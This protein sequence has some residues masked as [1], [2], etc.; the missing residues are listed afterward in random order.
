MRTTNAL[1]VAACA[2]LLAVPASA[3]DLQQK[4][5]AAK[6]SAAR[7]IDVTTWLDEPENA[8][9]FTITMQSLP[10]GTSHPATVALSI[11]K[12]QLVV[13]ITKSN[14]QKLAQ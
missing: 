5:A 9:N 8:V 10:D 4:L 13:K 6:E 14:Y 1:A 2:L 11:P 12:R 7:K 3:Q